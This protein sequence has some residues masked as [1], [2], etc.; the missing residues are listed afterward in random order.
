MPKL[1]ESPREEQ[2]PFPRTTKGAH[3]TRQ[4]HDTESKAT[5][6]GWRG[7]N[8]AGSCDEGERRFVPEDGE[9]GRR[10]SGSRG[11][12]RSHRAVHAYGPLGCQ[13]FPA[14]EVTSGFRAGTRTRCK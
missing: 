1:G 13:I 2:V 11:S 7:G 14:A 4:T 9:Q 6:G 10:A 5:R 12:L 8:G 3:S